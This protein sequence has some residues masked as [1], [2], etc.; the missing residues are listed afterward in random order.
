M[1]MS[2]LEKAI[3]CLAAAGACFVT[4]TPAMAKE[5]WTVPLG[6]NA[7]LTSS[8]A[9]SPDRVEASG[10]KQW[11][12][13]KSVFSMYFRADR[14]AVLDL[15]LRLKAPDGDSVIRA[16][17]AE[18]TF[19]IKVTGADFRNV[20][21][22]KITTDKE[23]YVRVD[24]QGLR[25][26]GAVFAEVGELVVES[27]TAGLKLDY[28]KDP[29]E[30]RFY[31]GRRGPSV[32]LGYE[33]PAG[34]TMEYF[35]SEVRVPEGQD[36]IGSYFMSNGFGEGYFGMQVKGTNERWILFSVW[37]PFHTN[38]PRDIPEEKRIELLAKGQDVRTGEFGNEGSGG[39]SFLVY[40]WKAGTTYRF[41]NRARPD[42]RGNTIYT[43]WFFAPEAGEW[44]LI[45]SFRRPETNKHL[46]GLHSF[47][48]NFADRNGYQGRMAYHGNQWARDTEENWHELTKA[49]FTG[50][51][52]ANR[53]Y[54]LDYAGGAE[55][56]EFFMRNGGF[57][58][59][60]V[61]PGTAFERKS[62][63]SKKPDID[64]DALEAAQ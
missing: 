7:Y 18:S 25:K 13:E 57:F 42:G 47:L 16:V 23:G 63:P 45:A 2:R 24:I 31:W 50:D 5:L 29:A 53:Q 22:G 35:Y 59:E 15:S 11:Q 40:P 27:E 54:R 33:L 1:M 21:L 61:K 9:G 34:K 19:E 10:I 14:A 55:G 3:V 26:T 49:R 51:D 43:A 20:P 28:V 36:P 30:N 39:K 64:L 52:I 46:T 4:I 17:V 56:D 6:G 32:H 48:E 12:N 38:N 8:A 60:T 37:S 41:L 44:K 58:A 62:N